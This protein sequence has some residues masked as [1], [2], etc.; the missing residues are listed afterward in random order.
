M[1]T[2]GFEKVAYFYI[3][4]K[5]AT[6][7]TMVVYR[8]DGNFVDPPPAHIMEKYKAYKKTVPGSKEYTEHENS[9]F[10][11]AKELTNSGRKHIKE[12]NF[13]LPGRRYPIHDAA[14]AR[15]ALARVA[16]NGSPEEQAAV[17]RAVHK[18]YPS[19]GEK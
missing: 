14:H 7:H 6:H 17:K 11:T 13:A 19:L 8:N 15:N 12:E 3:K 4:P 5:G 18:K 1:F 2:E 9:L 16:Q 10:K